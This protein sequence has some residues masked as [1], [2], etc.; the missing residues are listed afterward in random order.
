MQRKKHSAEF[1]AK[2]A[3]EALKGDKTINEIAGEHQ[4]HPN[5]VSNWKKEAQAGLI[6]CFSVKRGRK[7]LQHE[8]DQEALYS[9]IGRLKVEL[10]WLKK[11]SGLSL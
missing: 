7:N 4:V 11:K 9:Q 1:K 6:E 10:D 3:L 8:T 2:V 5:Q